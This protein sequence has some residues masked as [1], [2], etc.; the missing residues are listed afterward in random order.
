[1][2]S[3][4]LVWNK[5]DG[6]NQLIGSIDESLDADNTLI[7]GDTF[8]DLPMV[9]YGASKNKTVIVSKFK[10]KLSI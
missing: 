10:D 6:I 2:N 1:M 5:A 9:R 8:S 3:I 7:C 4:F